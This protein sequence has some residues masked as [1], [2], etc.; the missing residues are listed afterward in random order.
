MTRSNPI[1]PAQLYRLHFRRKGGGGT[2]PMIWAHAAS[3]VFRQ[4]PNPRHGE[5]GFTGF[6]VETL[7]H[8]I[9]AKQAL[10]EATG[11]EWEMLLLWTR[12]AK[13]GEGEGPRKGENPWKNGWPV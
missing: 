2:K 13:E 10:E 11:T 8:P 12:S 1:Y 7:Q 4:K 5:G 6:E 9:H 3:W